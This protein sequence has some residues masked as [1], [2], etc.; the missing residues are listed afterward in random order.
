LDTVATILAVV[1][2]AHILLKFTFF[3]MPYRRRRAALD[4]SYGG[5]KLHA[6]GT[7]DVAL[8]VICAVLVA[9]LFA[10]GVSA[11]SFL[12][13]LWVGATLIQLYFHNYWQRLDPEREPPPPAGPIKWVSYA[14]QDRPWKPWPEIAAL[15][16]LVI[17][18]FVALAN[19]AT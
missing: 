13:G 1:F 4:K 17:A 5:G 12:I 18:A 7:S 2:G 3:L 19:G 10:A 16:I 11:V 9:V 15:Y 14:I 8:L 6:T